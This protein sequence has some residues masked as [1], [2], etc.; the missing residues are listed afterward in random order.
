MST[1]VPAATDLKSTLE[2]MR[3]SV[4]AEAERN[5][6]AGA[7]AAAFLRLLEMLVTLLADF[8]AG[9]LA[10]VIPSADAARFAAPDSDAEEAPAAVVADA[11]GAP[12]AGWRGLWAWWRGRKAADR[13]AGTSPGFGRQRS[14]AADH[15]VR[16]DADRSP[17]AP[18]R[19]RSQRAVAAQCETLEAPH[20]LGT[21]LRSSA[22]SAVR[23]VNRG[24]RGE[25]QRRPA[26][27]RGRRGPNAIRMTCCLPGLAGFLF[28]IFLKRDFWGGEVCVRIVAIS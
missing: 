1:A 11:G 20:R 16:G 7:V 5:R 19:G 13:L 25:A 4:G 15:G 28:G 24:E 3:A 17:N 14:E 21:T 27:R 10:A 8:R 23:I 6:L 2:E 22:P 26:L 18:G 12:V 9:T